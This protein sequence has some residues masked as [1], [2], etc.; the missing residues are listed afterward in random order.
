MGAAEEVLCLRRQDWFNSGIKHGYRIPEFNIGAGVVDVEMCAAT[1]GRWVGVVFSVG[2][3]ALHFLG[4]GGGILGVSGPT[5]RKRMVQMVSES[6]SFV[7]EFGVDTSFV[8]TS[9]VGAGVPFGDWDGVHWLC[10]PSFLQ[11]VFVACP[12]S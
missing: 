1:F 2:T 6:V 11:I 3:H 5:G 12:P 10:V 7:E 8:D 9:W 4:D